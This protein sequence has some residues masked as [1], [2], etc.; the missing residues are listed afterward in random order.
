MEKISAQEVP[1]DLMPQYR[2]FLSE[3]EKLYKC[4]PKL[5]QEFKMWPRETEWRP[6]STFKYPEF[7]RKL[8]DRLD[9]FKR[10]LM[11]E[12]PTK[13]KD[14]ITLYCDLFLKLEINPI[15]INPVQELRDILSKKQWD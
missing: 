14:V 7:E 12:N 13:Y 15:N 3:L 6:A 11:E 10:R 2:Q 5:A 8:W 4:N 1:T 9:A